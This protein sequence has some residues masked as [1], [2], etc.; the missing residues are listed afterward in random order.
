MEL[1][2]AICI[3]SVPDP[4]QSDNIALDPVTKTLIRSDVDAVINPADLSAIEFGIR[5]KETYGGTIT[6]I[7]MGPPSVDK[8]L[9]SGLSYGADRAVLLSDRAFG[10]ADSLATAY[11]L[12]EGIRKAGPFDLVLLGEESSDGATAHVPSQ[13]GEL[14]D[15]PHLI[16][17]TEC[18]VLSDEKVK[19]KRKTDLWIT[20]LEVEMPAVLAVSRNSVKVRTPN[21]RDIFSAKKKKLDVFSISDFPEIDTKAIGL[22]GSATQNGELHEV[23]FGRK[24]KEI[25]GTPEE[26]ADEIKLLL[27]TFVSTR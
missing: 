16:G 17:C 25:S 8:Q 12:A 3:K 23:S 6:L 4:E 24:A 13:V 1:K 27:Q 11:T 15:L 9:R 2:I 10:G 7:S 19:V 5:L 21:V 14:L 26:I 20:E 22:H 18:T